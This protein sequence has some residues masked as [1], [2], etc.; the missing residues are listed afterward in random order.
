MSPAFERCR[1]ILLEELEVNER[2]GSPGQKPYILHI[3]SLTERALGN[4]DEALAYINESIDVV[5]QH[6][7]V[8]AGT[9]HQMTKASLLWQLGRT[10]EALDTWQ[11]AVSQL[12]SC[13]HAEGL[14]QALKTLSDVL[15]GLDRPAEAE[16]YLEE[17]VDLFVQLEDMEG[18][19]SIWQRLGRVREQLGKYRE[20]MAACSTIAICRASTSSARW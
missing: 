20:A 2:L 1:A 7:T 10:D 13:R 15:I 14:S 8:I 17:A 9:F 5:D 4:L 3:L 11:L 18:A 6:H 12:R 19:A 16:P